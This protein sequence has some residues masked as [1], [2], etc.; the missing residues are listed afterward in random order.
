MWFIMKLYLGLLP[1]IDPCYYS[2]VSLLAA[3]Q[4]IN[5]L[6]NIQSAERKADVK[7]S[8]PDD[9]NS[10]SVSVSLNKIS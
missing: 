3:L 2:S 5:E 10:T 1:L 8:L 4:R 7:L 6:V 9:Y